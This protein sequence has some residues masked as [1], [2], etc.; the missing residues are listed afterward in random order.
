VSFTALITAVTESNG[1][2]VVCGGGVVCGSGFVIR[3]S[4][5]FSQGHF[6]LVIQ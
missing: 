2:D 3:I 1:G 4:A 5:E 6:H